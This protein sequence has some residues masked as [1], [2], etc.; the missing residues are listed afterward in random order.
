MS[1]QEDASPPWYTPPLDP[2]C[3]PHESAAHYVWSLVCQLQTLLVL[4]A[5]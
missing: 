3:Q 1:A 2:L 5:F 4:G